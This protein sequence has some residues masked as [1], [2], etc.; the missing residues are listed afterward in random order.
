MN[1]GAT[2]NPGNKDK[3]MTLSL[4][5]DQLKAAPTYDPDKPPKIVGAPAPRST[6]APAP[7]AAAA[8]SPTPTPPSS[9]DNGGK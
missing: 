1:S 8:T 5:K 2:G 3:P 7:P 6:A 9:P 4:H